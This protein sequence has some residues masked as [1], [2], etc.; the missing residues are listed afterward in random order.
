[1]FLRISFQWDL[2]QWC[3][4]AFFVLCAL[5]KIN[6]WQFEHLI[7][8]SLASLNGSKVLSF[9]II[10]LEW[11]FN[12]ITDKDLQWCESEFT[13]PQMHVPHPSRKILVQ[14]QNKFFLSL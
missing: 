10:M 4:Y 9:R 8:I 5:P 7:W 14:Q 13:S 3:K 12:P 2:K 1:L 11:I 6:K